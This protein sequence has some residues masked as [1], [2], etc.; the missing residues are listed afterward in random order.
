VSRRSNLASCL[1][2][3]TLCLTVGGGFSLAA[4]PSADELDDSSSEPRHRNH[5]EERVSVT[6]EV[7]ESASA[8]LGASSTVIEPSSVAGT[9]STVADVVVQTASVAKNGQGGHLQVFSIRG[10][11]R[12]RVLNLVSG[13]RINSERRAGA[14]ISFVDPLL[15]DSAEVLRGPATT[16]HGSGAL[17]GV[18]QVFPRAE[19]GWSLRTGYDTRGNENYQVFGYGKENWAVG[20]ARRDAGNTNA[21]DGSELNTHFTQ[22]SATVQGGWGNGPRRYELLYL[23]SRALDVGKSNTD[24]PERTTTYPSERHQLLE[25]SVGSEKSWQARAWLHPH[26]LET[27]VVREGVSRNRVL[28]ESFDYGLGFEQDK[29]TSPEAWI[30]WG[31]QLFGRENVSATEVEQ[32]LAPIPSPDLE[33]MTLDDASDLEAGGFAT[34]R[35]GLGRTEFEVG[36]RLAWIAQRN[37]DD[38]SRR[39]WGPS[40]F[41]GVTHRLSERLELRG[42]LSSGLRF[43]SLS[44]QFFSGTTGAGSILGNP[45][46]EPERSLNLEG[47][48]HWAGR[49]LFL[50]GTVFSNR[51]DDYIQREP[52]TDA[53]DSPLTF[54]NLTSGTL[55]GFELQGLFRPTEQW[56]V[57]FGG[58]IISG[59]DDDGRRLTD[60][61]PNQIYVGVRYARRAWNFGARVSYDDSI[62]DPAPGEKTIPSALLVQAS[63]D[64]RISATWLVALTGANLTD[65]NYFAAADRKAPLEPGRSIGVAFVRRP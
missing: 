33:L 27:E 57:D 29:Q 18:V 51:I 31:V 56:G 58:Q 19:D 55:R 38:P 44:E 25:F 13:V 9:P 40:G 54:R 16:L 30:R 36:G 50:N 48:V 37:A 1:L 28:N 26:E 12:H 47:S 6:A 45:E 42:S 3:A 53:P 49:T 62:A 61:P 23:P 65:E 64:H 46:L 34:Y 63:V 11:S 59:T 4:N 10:L 60:V 41:A 52:V 43:P 5:H 24:F 17:G 35:R 21:A 8:P 15:L 32:S 20:V 7:R 14:S 2:A 22:Y 39:R